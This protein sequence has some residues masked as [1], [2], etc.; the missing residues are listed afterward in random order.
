MVKFKDNLKTGCK[1]VIVILSKYNISQLKAL[2]QHFK[3][4]IDDFSMCTF[5]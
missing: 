3:G 5:D 4:L 1:V 2:I